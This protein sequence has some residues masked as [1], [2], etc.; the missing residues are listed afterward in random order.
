MRCRVGF[1]R[2]SWAKSCYRAPDSAP[3]RLRLP[4]TMPSLSRNSADAG[5]M[6]LF[7]LQAVSEYTGPAGS[8]ADK[9]CPHGC[10]L[11]D[12]PTAGGAYAETGLTRMRLLLCLGALNFRHTAATCPP[13]TCSSPIPLTRPCKGHCASAS[14]ASCIFFS[15]ILSRQTASKAAMLSCRAC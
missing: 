11:V 8:G 1:C 3:K 5:K 14:V 13:S 10:A 7:C 15:Y 6:A 9:T 4:E 2:M 12:R